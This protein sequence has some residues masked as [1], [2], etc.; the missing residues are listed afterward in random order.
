MATRPAEIRAPRPAPSKAPSRR[1]RLRVV[2]AKQLREQH[3]I[4]R[5]RLMIGFS[6]LLFAGALLFVAAGQAVVVSQQLQ[7]DNAQQQLSTA[8]STNT[9]LQ[10]ER[11]SLDSPARILQL[12][13]HKLGMVTPTSVVYLVPVKVGPTVGSL[14]NSVQS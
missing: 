14:K 9:N 11:A 13:Q 1:P 3:K 4:R 5:A 12:A 2:N 8:S 6:A 10:I 7:L